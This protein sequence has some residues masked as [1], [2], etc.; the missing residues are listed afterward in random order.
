MVRLSSLL[1]LV[2]SFCCMISASSFAQTVP[3]WVKT[4]NGPAGGNDLAPKMAV[5]ALGNTVVAATEQ[6]S[7]TQQDWV[8]IKYDAV[9]T[10]LWVR[11]WNNAP[12]N[13]NDYPESIAIDS[14][15]NILVT[16]TCWNGLN[17]NGTGG[18]EYDI[19]LLKYAPDGTL[20]WERRWDDPIRWQDFAYGVKVDRGDNVIVM[21]WSSSRS[22]NPLFPN[23]V[24]NDFV[25]LKYNPSGTLLWT[26]VYNGPDQ[27]GDGG[28]DMTLDAAG[29]IYVTGTT[30]RWA[31]GTITDGLTI[32]YGPGG[33]VLWMARIP[34]RSDMA[35]NANNPTRVRVDAVGNVYVAGWDQ[36]AAPPRD[37]MLLKYNSSGVLQWK[38]NWSR[39]MEDVLYDM[40]LDAQGNPILA[41]STEP[42]PSKGFPDSDAALLKYDANGN[43]LWQHIYNGPSNLWDGDNVLAQDSLGNIYVGLQSQSVSYDYTLLKYTPGGVLQTVW[44][45]DSPWHKDD[46]VFAM[47]FGPD[48]LLRMSGTANTT[49]QGLDIL[50]L[51]VDTTTLQGGIAASPSSLMLS[52]AKISPGQTSIA[53]VL[54]DRPAPAGG[55]SLQLASSDT[56]TAWVQGWL[57]IPAGQ[58]SGSAVVNTGFAS[59]PS[60]VTISATYNGR[61]VSS[62]LQVGQVSTPTVSLSSLTISPSTVTG[63]TAVMG[64]VALTGTA[65]S[66]VVVT[67]SSSSSLAVP[68]ASV[69]I[70]I[71]SAGANFTIPTGVVSATTL[72]TITATAGSVSKSASLTLSPKVTTPTDTVAIQKA[73]YDTNKKR[74]N[75]QATSTGSAATLTAYVTGTNALIGTLSNNGGGKYSAN[76]NLS[77]NPQNI[78]VKSSLGG[79]ASRAVVRK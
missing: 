61:T 8:I 49:A 16:G 45:Y 28:Q 6:N 57:D 18:T 55:V 51:S 79:S 5:D 11:H 65:T 76:F 23:F 53:A 37:V 66:D 44:K 52:P 33:N 22:T 70:P 71:G 48:G 59:A 73:E 62:I 10:Q 36:V 17:V 31:G 3:A 56:A 9:G 64:T 19:V 20:L 77:A 1:L 35:S 24:N 47:A 63:G 12:V 41:V 34:G 26:S 29:N 15:G 38:R 21:G 40:Q 25:T 39:A 46:S 58:S 4:Y 32:K 27:M 30:S 72:I 2:I 43:L 69:T 68:P 67:L 42:V 50:T 75:V 14:G 60:A 7:A 78:T 13:G 74:L 54:L